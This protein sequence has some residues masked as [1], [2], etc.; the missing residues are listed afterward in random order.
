ML[1]EVCARLRHLSR[2]ARAH[3]CKVLHI[4]IQCRS[5]SV[6]ECGAAAHTRVCVLGHRRS[7]AQLGASVFARLRP[8]EAR[9]QSD[10]ETRTTNLCNTH[11]S[12]LIAVLHACVRTRAEARERVNLGLQRNLQHGPDGA[13]AVHADAAAVQWPPMLL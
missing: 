10:G 11:M 6:C 2:N 1:A 9:I 12:M 4:R 5:A 8:P 3:H 13:Q 7:G